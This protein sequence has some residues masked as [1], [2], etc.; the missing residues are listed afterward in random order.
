[1]CVFFVIG[2]GMGC[3]YI[4]DWFV[5]L[6]GGCD[7][8][9]LWCNELLYDCVV[10]CVIYDFIRSFVVFFFCMSDFDLCGK[11]VLICEDLNVLIEN[12]CII[13]IQC[14]DVLFFIIC[15]VCD[16]GVQVMVFLYLGCLKEGQFDEDFLFVLVVV[17]LGDKFGMLVWLVCDY[18][19]GVEVVDGEVVVLENCCMN[20]GEGKDDEVLLK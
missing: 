3:K 1:M 9:W 11:C 5:L 6:Q 14:L 4:C 15:V 12:G 7:N 19:G 17:W 18:L 2:Q 13:F 16:V 8:V 20:V 10:V